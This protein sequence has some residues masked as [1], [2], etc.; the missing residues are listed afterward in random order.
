MQES[1]TW[2]HELGSVGF[3]ESTAKSLSTVEAPFALGGF[4]GLD[5]VHGGLGLAKHILVTAHTLGHIAPPNTN[6]TLRILSRSHRPFEILNVL[7]A[8]L[9]VDSA[10]FIGVTLHLLVVGLLVF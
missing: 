8:H 6:H 2:W 7:G 5:E 10:H 4:W 9:I 3:R 1:W